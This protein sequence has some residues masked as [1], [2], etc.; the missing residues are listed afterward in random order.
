MREGFG[1]QPS[2]EDDESS[3]RGCFMGNPSSLLVACCMVVGLS[4]SAA[5]AR[6]RGDEVLGLDECFSGD[7]DLAR[8]ELL[9]IWL[10]SFGF[11]RGGNDMA[12]VPG[13][14]LA[15]LPSRLGSERL[16]GSSRRGGS[17]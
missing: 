10:T 1:A 11:G 6:L 4:S 17:S 9:E 7:D 5:K 14:E 3:R 8:L 12:E 16:K 2:T 13:L 15:L